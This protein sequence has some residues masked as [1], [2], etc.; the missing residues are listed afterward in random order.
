MAVAAY[1][2]TYL[3]MFYIHMLIHSYT[4]VHIYI[5]ISNTRQNDIG[6]CFGIYDAEMWA[7]DWRLLQGLKVWGYCSHC[8]QLPFL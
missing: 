1:V 2:L 6:S 5:C 7:L 8:W 4:H 3:H